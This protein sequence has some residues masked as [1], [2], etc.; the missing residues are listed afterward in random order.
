MDS[1][2]IH[3]TVIII[4]F[5]VKAANGTHPLSPIHSA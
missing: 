1:Q 3:K 5:I 2:W 4:D